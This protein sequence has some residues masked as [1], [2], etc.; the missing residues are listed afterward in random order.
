MG[1]AA[2]AAVVL[3]LVAPQTSDRPARVP[4]G[5]DAALDRL[6]AGTPVFN[7][8]ELGGWLA[9]RHPD[10]EQYIDGLA[11]PYSEAHVQ[12]YVRADAADPGWYG[13]IASPDA[14]VALVASDSALARAWRARVGPPKAGPTA[15]CC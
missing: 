12:D 10:L 2:L 6:P 9:W 14:R 4:V 8:Y 1:A 3:A 13:V 5:L 7:A 11:T 15:T